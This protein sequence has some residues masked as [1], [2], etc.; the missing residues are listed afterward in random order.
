VLVALLCYIPADVV[1]A[2]DDWPTLLHRL[3]LII[4]FA[5]VR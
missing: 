2:R 1:V 5:A 4:G 3:L